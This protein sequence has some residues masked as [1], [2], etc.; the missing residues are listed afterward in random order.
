MIALSNMPDGL[1]CWTTLIPQVRVWCEIG[2]IC[3]LFVVWN[4]AACLISQTVWGA[5]HSQLA[6]HELHSFSSSV[7]LQKVTPATVHKEGIE[8]SAFGMAA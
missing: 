5:G 8:F 3:P 1:R 7:S 4:M 6:P 2:T